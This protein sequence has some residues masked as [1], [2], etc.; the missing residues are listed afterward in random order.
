MLFRIAP[1]SVKSRLPLTSSTVMPGCVFCKALFKSHHLFSLLGNQSLL[2]FGCAVQKNIKQ[3][4]DVAFSLQGFHEQRMPF[5]L[6]LLRCVLPFPCSQ[7]MEV[8]GQHLIAPVFFLAVSLFRGRRSYLGSDISSSKNIF[9]F[10]VNF[11]S[12]RLTM[13]CEMRII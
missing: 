10:F 2:F 3:I 12:N 6:R 9:I 5:V 13:Q 11:S 8:I 4:F 1:L 7:V